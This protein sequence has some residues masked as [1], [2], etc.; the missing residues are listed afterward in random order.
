MRIFDK[1]GRLFGKMSVI[2]LMVLVII[3]IAV[4]GLGVRLFKTDA[5]NRKNV[6]DKAVRIA[7]YLEEV[8]DYVA[9]QVSIQDPVREAV[10][11]KSFGVVSG[12]EL[13][14]SVSWGE[15]KR[16]EKVAS[17][18]DGYVS[19]RVEMDVNGR[20]DGSGIVLQNQAYHIGQTITLL[21]GNAALQNGRIVAVHER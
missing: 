15:T 4:T 1:G 20:F 5:L 8:P 3:L 21:V 14:P 6:P 13:A 17:T 7:F 2:D 12:I 9:N 10:Q 19:I 16:G 18:K 11:S